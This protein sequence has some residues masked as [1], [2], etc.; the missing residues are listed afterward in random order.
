M[1]EFVAGRGTTALGIIGT[2]LG[3]IGTAAA[4]GNGAGL[5]NNI[6]GGGNCPRAVCSEDHLVNRYEAAQEAKISELQTQIALRDANTYS[7]QK[8]LEVYKYFDGEIKDIRTTICANREAQAVV[9]AN[10]NASVVALNGQVA[11][12]AATLAGITR[13]A[14]PQSSICNFGC[15]CCNS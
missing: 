1:A 11:A 10:L 9:N 13:T 12:T 7:D 2:V 5:L 4:T 8:L 14:V 15:G 6:V 3:S